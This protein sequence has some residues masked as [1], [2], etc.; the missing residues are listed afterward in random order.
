MNNDPNLEEYPR[1]V[2]PDVVYKNKASLKKPAV[3]PLYA[4][5]LSAA[6]AV[7]LLF[8]LLWRPLMM[9]R[10]ELLVAMKPV[11]DR[12]ILTEEPSLMASCQT[13]VVFPGKTVKT[14]PSKVVPAPMKREA[15]PLL[16][17]M[18]PQTA[19]LPTF[20][21][22]QLLLERDPLEFYE[23]ASWVQEEEDG[24]YD[25]HDDSRLSFLRRG[26]LMITDGQFESFGG[27]LQSGWQSAKV[28]IAQLNEAVAESLS[29]VKPGDSYFDRDDDAQSWLLNRLKEQ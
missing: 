23:L 25:D 2:A 17:A 8:V 29:S 6:A 28:E 3:I 16:V 20:R 7:A 4:K 18:E 9:P 5:V 11:G 24:A 14:A 27:M 12:R 10:Q 19:T 26:F 1:L 21:Y 15:L 13:P 22:G